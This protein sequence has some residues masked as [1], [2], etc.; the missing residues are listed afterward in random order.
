M[1]T[2]IAAKPFASI[3]IFREGK[4]IFRT[5]PAGQQAILCLPD[6]QSQYFCFFHGAVQNLFFS[7]KVQSCL[8]NNFT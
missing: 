8:L 5:S 1:V 2:E 3:F 4:C 6:K 7:Q